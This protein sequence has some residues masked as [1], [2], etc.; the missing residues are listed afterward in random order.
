VERR[1]ILASASPRRR[2]LLHKALGGFEV[3]PSQAEES[4]SSEREPAELAEENALAK[5]KDVAVEH[6]EALVIGADTVVVHNG[7]ILGKPKSRGE[8]LEMLRLLSNDTHNVITGLAIVCIGRGISIAEHESTEVRFRKLDDRMLN[9]YLNNFEYL[10]KAGA[11]GIQDIGD[12]F[13]EHLHGDIDNV[14]GFPLK[15]FSKMLAKIG[16]M[17][18]ER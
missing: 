16:K 15:L 17:M 1:I 12:S 4:S 9:E 2:A 8:A 11:Y 6:T 18:G 7:R 14:I 10:D 3:I 13:V 5:A